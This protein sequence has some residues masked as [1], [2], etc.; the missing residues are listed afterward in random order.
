MLPVPVGKAAH[1]GFVQ[2][3]MT[4]TESSVL[5]KGSRL[6]SIHD[7]VWRKVIPQTY[8]D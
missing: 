7:N 4:S 5:S 3:S 2:N 6:L 1:R 8:S